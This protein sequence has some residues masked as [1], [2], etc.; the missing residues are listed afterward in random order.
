MACDSD[1]HPGLSR[2]PW[3][4]APLLAP[5]L[6]LL[7]PGAAA[8]AAPAG[9]GQRVAQG[10]RGFADRM[11]RE[12]GTGAAPRVF[13]P[14]NLY[15]TLGLLGLG[16]TGA[17]A[18]AFSTAM[19]LPAGRDSLA[20]A[21][22]AARGMAGRATTAYSAWSTPA[23]G[24]EPA[25]RTLARGA[26]APRLGQLDFASPQAA[27]TINRWASAATRGEIPSV[28]DQLPA[29]TELLL[30]GAI[31]FAGE[32]AQRFDPA[33]TAPGAFRRADGTSVQVPMMRLD[34]RVAYGMRDGAHVIRL[35]YAGGQMAI[36]VATAL[37]PAESRAVLSRIAAQGA[38]AWLAGV[39]LEQVRCAVRLPKMSLTA[40][41]D[42][43]DAVRRAGFATALAGDFSAI[44][45]RPARIGQIAHQARIRVD[46]AGTVAAAATAIGAT[47]SMEEAR[48]FSADRPFLF[49]LGPVSPA[50][51]LFAGMVDDPSGGGA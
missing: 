32:W 16:A 25:W 2:R 37:E 46:E 48:E 41:G 22:A 15:C 21:L 44:T 31:H 28:V 12:A 14:Y 50:L 13:S 24:F 30:A 43:L 39:T 49:V 33:A 11:L 18:A 51:P 8:R 6:A 47:R 9:Q 19:G 36:W 34:G 27:E 20:A 7:P 40:G 10:V 45:G 23:R 38:T 17:T 42:M 1:D 29:D 35:P 5:F 26:L 3:L 4:A